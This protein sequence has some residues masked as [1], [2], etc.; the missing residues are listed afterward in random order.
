MYFFSDSTMDSWDQI[1]NT[2]T[3]YKKKCFFMIGIFRPNIPQI[4]INY[5][6]IFNRPRTALSQNNVANNIL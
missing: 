5:Q 6:L 1:E 4:P 2:W 3:K